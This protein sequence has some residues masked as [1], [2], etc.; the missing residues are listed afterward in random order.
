MM[1]RMGSAN[2]SDANQRSRQSQH[3]VHLEELLA[4][5]SLI[6]DIVEEGL[7]ARQN[8]AEV[9][10]TMLPAV[11]DRLGARGAFV[12]SFGEDLT[13]QLFTH[14]AT[15]AIPRKDDVFERTSGDHRESAVVQE[16]GE[17]MVAQPLDVA[18]EWF[19]CAGLVL[20]KS[21]PRASDPNRL[22]E[23]LNL[24]CEELDNYLFAIRAAREKHELMM[25]L[26]RALRHRVLG[27]GLRQAVEVLTK[28]I[29]LHRMLLVYVAEEN[30]ESTLHIHLFDGGGAL[31]EN[32]V[33]TAAT[34]AERE[35]IS[36]EGRD[37]LQGRSTVLLARLGFE[38]AQEEVLI[39]GVTKSVVVGKVV[40]SSK[41]GSFNTYS[42]ELLGG[43]AGFI[44]Q[45]VVDFN[46]E[47]RRLAASFR[48][49]DVA[50]L[51]QRDDYESRL[52]APREEPVAILY[53]DIA[54]F[55]RL[56][57]QVLKTPSAVAELVEDWSKD[58]VDLVWE[59]G[60]VFDK[61]VGDCVIALFGP[62]FYENTPGE[63]LARA[64]DCAVAIRDM[65]RRLPERAKFE[66]LRAEGV[67]VSTGVNL[68][69]LFVG[70]FG[71]NSSAPG[72]R[73]ARSDPR[74]GRLDRAAPRGPQ[75]SLQR[76]AE[77][78]REERRCAAAVPRDHH[79]ELQRRPDEP[80]PA[81][82]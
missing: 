46:K 47:W 43:F 74:D 41:H 28:A 32:L 25:E 59:H 62:P 60:G 7:I 29:D 27:E 70:T 6:D 69:P 80:E 42:R 75:I 13:M 44:R 21:N 73:Q 53:V 31:K 54:G 57:E 20:D 71:P 23:L 34:D 4:L 33:A 22:K 3:V 64:I 18:G 48:P 16:G 35:Q 17:I 36:R 40:A 45:R 5:R 81:A 72:L 11:C 30:A 12:R 78:H 24:M 77:R 9:M 67:A 58:A 56:S 61:M 8:L 38:G 39:N 51:L 52:L 66:L 15:L 63:C 55:T 68:A 79:A 37:Y 82:G 2:D 49:E 14:P 50:R 65:T 1:A 26:A 76:G 10:A 19:G